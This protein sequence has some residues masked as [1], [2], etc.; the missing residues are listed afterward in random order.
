MSEMLSKYQ[1]QPT[2]AITVMILI[3]QLHH[4]RLALRRQLSMARMMFVTSRI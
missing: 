4:V 2:Y 1:S 3:S